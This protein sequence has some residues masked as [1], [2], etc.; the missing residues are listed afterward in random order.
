MLGLYSQEQLKEEYEQDNVEEVNPLTEERL[1]EE[2]L[3]RE[4]RSHQSLRLLVL[5]GA[6]TLLP[7]RGR[8]LPHSRDHKS[9]S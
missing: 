5:R 1:K 6:W 7:E 8:P 9:A 3:A 4:V 2:V